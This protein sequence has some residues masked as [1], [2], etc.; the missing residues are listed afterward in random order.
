MWRGSGMGRLNCVRLVKHITALGCLVLGRLL[1]AIKFMKYFWA[2][3]A[4]SPRAIGAGYG[5]QYSGLKASELW[6]EDRCRHPDRATRRRQ[7][8]CVV[9][10]AG[11]VAGATAFMCA[12]YSYC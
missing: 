3:R 12:R 8:A 10:N 6:G 2:G 5:Y 4:P 9:G 1:R 7:S 11:S